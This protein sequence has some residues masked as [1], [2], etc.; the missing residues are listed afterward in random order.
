M[1]RTSPPW[2]ANTWRSPLS[3]SRLLTD[4]SLLPS[5]LLLSECP[6]VLE[7]VF[8][9]FQLV[10]LSYPCTIFFQSLAS[11]RISLCNVLQSDCGILKFIGFEHNF[12][13]VSIIIC[14]MGGAPVPPPLLIPTQ[15]QA[16]PQTT[17]RFRNCKNTSQTNWKILYLQVRLLYQLELTRGRD[18]KGREGW[19]IEWCFPRGGI[20]SVT[21]SSP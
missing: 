1:L 10:C 4:I 3:F 2:A 17:L 16:F 7:A 8:R 6:S 19:D 13:I 20:A 18:A 12:K 9:I 21:S 15:P 14:I 5:I 11:F